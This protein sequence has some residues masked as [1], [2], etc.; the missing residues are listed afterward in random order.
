MGKTV[1]NSVKNV[2]QYIISI[3]VIISV[4]SLC[5]L[6][7]NLIDYKVVAL[8]LMVTV[9]LTAMFFDIMPVLVSALLSALIWNFFFISPKFTFHIDNAEDVLLFFMYFIIA[10]VNAVLTFKIRAIEKIASKKEEK[11]NSLK[12]YKTLLNSLSHELRTPIATIIGATDNLQTENTNLSENNKAELIA[13]ISKAT[14]RLNTQ[15]ENLLNMSR[16]ES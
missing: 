15:V 9:S 12:L 7:S 1:L 11:E 5:Y 14:L 8:V 6:S 16:L 4:A 3:S 13:A 10:L 2:Y